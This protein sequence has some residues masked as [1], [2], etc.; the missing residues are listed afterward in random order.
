MGNLR[1]VANAFDSLGEKVCVTQDPQ[2]LRK[3]SAIVLPGVG[4]FGQGMENLRR[5]NLL[6]PLNEEVIGK[7]KPYL[8]LCLGMQFLARESAEFGRHEGLGWIGGVVRELKP[9]EP[10]FKVPHMGWNNVEVRARAPLF[11]GMGESPVFYFVHS[12]VLEMDAAEQEKISAV[13]WH[14]TTVVAS[15]QQGNIYGVQFHP[16][17]SQQDGLKLLENFLQ[18]I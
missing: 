17:K 14:G 13:C 9:A 4:A 7:G 12:L 11:E 1:S 6:E 16:E 10:G 8:G 5:L 3:A 15:V 2:D 18:L